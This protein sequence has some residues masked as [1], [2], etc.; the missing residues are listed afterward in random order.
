[1]KKRSIIFSGFL[2]L[3]FIFSACTPAAEGGENQPPSVDQVATMTGD[4][5]AAG[6]GDA[7][8]FQKSN[9]LEKWTM[10]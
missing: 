9:G 6:G 3:I 5:A 10:S 1:M 7:P 8:N 4:A 2:I